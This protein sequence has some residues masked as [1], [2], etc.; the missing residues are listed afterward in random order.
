MFFFWCLHLFFFFSSGAVKHSLTTVTCAKWCRIINVELRLFS[1]ICWLLAGWYYKKKKKEKM[2]R[3]QCT[4]WEFWEQE[5]EEHIKFWS[6][7]R[8]LKWRWLWGSGTDV[9]SWVLFRLYIFTTSSFCSF[10]SSIFHIYINH[11]PI[12]NLVNYQIC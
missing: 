1:S 9:L 12:V 11:L 7:S 6:R 3:F 10:Y 8:N 5:K 4:C 2:D